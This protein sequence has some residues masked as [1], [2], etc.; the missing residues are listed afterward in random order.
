MLNPRATLRDTVHRDLVLELPTDVRTIEHAV[1]YVIGRCPCCA[2]EARRLRQLLD[3]RAG[4][5]AR[6][7]HV[8]EGL[9]DLGG[10]ELAR[11]NH[12]VAHSLFLN[13]QSITVDNAW[14]ARWVGAARAAAGAGGD[15]ISLV[16]ARLDADRTGIVPLLQR[17]AQRVFGRAGA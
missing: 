8:E 9:V 6:P 1:D 16:V 13:A 14:A 7:E 12:R 2:E 5:A 11:A 3:R 4:V 10:I 17:L 15:N